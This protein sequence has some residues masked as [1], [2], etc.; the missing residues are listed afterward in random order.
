[1]DFMLRLTFRPINPSKE[2]ATSAVE[3]LAYRPEK[4]RRRGSS[5]PLQFSC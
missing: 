4:K 3:V 2:L 1:M 5:V